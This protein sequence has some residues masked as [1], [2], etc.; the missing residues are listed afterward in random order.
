M[1]KIRSIL[2]ALFSVIIVLGVLAIFI[3]TGSNKILDYINTVEHVE[4][5]NL[6][7]AKDTDGYWTITNDNDSTPFKILQLS[8]VH[9]GSSNFVQK[10]DQLALTAIRD[11]VGATKP[12]LVIFTGDILYP[13]FFRSGCINNEKMIRNF[14]AFMDK[15]DVYWAPV[16][17]NHDGESFA[18]WN[19]EKLSTYYE[20]LDKCLFQR[21]PTDIDGYGNYVIKL[22][23]SDSTLN[24]A[25]FLMD[26]QAYYNGNMLR[27]DNIHDNQVDWYKSTIDDLS[28]GQSLPIQSMIY[29][30][31]PDRIYKTAWDLYK[32]GSAEVVYHFG[33]KD[34][35]IHCSREEGKLWDAIIEKASTKAMF[36]GHDHCNNFSISYKGV[37]L[38][39]GLSIDYTAYPF[40][41]Q[42]SAQRGGTLVK[43]DKHKNYT[44][45]QI[46]Q[47]NNYQEQ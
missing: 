16:F 39:Y 25:L 2:T 19:K 32:E 41:K 42:H 4:T 3:A 36:C 21:G 29:C 5:R 11:V 23:N 20:S 13:S 38:T 30:H 24:T 6:L 15:L 34:D 12:D 14:G 43:I 9:F 28:E 45:K 26:S 31:I 35:G 1:K 46:F 7:V 22:L 40:M 33:I 47:D 44:I 8:D 10:K 17:G 18:K 27:Y 37:Q